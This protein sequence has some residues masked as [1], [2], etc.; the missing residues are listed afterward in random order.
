MED[1]LKKI[2]ENF[3]HKKFSLVE[4]YP[5]DVYEY[6]KFRKTFKK[7]LDNV[8]IVKD[9]KRF[10]I[11]K[12]DYTSISPETF[13]EKK[14]EFYE[15]SRNGVVIWN[16]EF[17]NLEGLQAYYPLIFVKNI[18][19]KNL[20]QIEFEKDLNDWKTVYLQNEE[21][22]ILINKNIS[23]FGSFVF[24]DFVLSKKILPK[25]DIV[26]DFKLK[27]K[28]Y[29]NYDIFKNL[30]KPTI[31]P[32]NKTN[33]KWCQEFYTYILELLK[34]LVPVEKEKYIP[35]IINKGNL[36]SIWFRAFTHFT[37]DPNINKNYES[38]ETIGDKVLKLS[39]DEYF[40]E[41]HPLSTPGDLK[42]ISNETQSEEPQAELSQ[43]MGL[44]NWFIGEEIIRNNMKISE[45]L[46]ES[47]AGAV[48]LALYQG[49]IIGGSS[50]I[51]NNM[52]KKIYKDYA[53]V[54][55]INAPTFLDQ[56]ISRIVPRE[57]KPVLNK[58]QNYISLA[59]P[60]NIDPETY[61]QIIDQSNNLL[62]KEGKEYLLTSEK[63]KEEKDKGIE[64][65][66]HI[67][68]DKKSRVDVRVNEYGSKVFKYYGINIKK[69]QI[70][71]TSTETSA[72]PAKRHAS[73]NARDYLFS[74]GITDNWAD[75][76]SYIKKMVEFEGFEEKL[77]LKAKN[78]HKDI[79]SFGIASKELKKDKIFLLYG[80]NKKGFKYP[81]ETYISEEKF[82]NNYVN[83]AQKFL[84]D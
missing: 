23:N 61:K 40:F 27:P 60:K 33:I 81:L 75:K 18:K 19:D 6:E 49:G 31:N 82:G 7:E 42:N 29:I 48:D 8:V 38:L 1:N 73:D 22:M 84:E 45:D 2:L 51:F 67:T 70:I 66:V 46:L 74:K 15:K 41:K 17:D 36:E 52:Y 12:P 35:Y 68:K 24:E 13:E 21:L 43:K 47:F 78:I 59:R 64:W 16:F 3:K 72:K 53:L 10:N 34:I 37:V 54:P 28:N 80:E 69:N 77:L 39:F 44:K 32:P 63:I 20:F 58:E 11:Q 71:G 83:L 25:D 30:P 55:E 26:P 57:I 62:T 56:I 76:Q 4:I 65:D 5:E 14:T 9:K 50:V 79:I